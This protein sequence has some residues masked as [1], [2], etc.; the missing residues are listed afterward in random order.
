VSAYVKTVIASLQAQNPK[1]KL[2]LQSVLPREAEAMSSV[3]AYN[4]AYKDLAESMNVDYIDMVEAFA[5]PDGT[6]RSNLTY[7]GLHFNEEGYR[8]WAAQL[9]PYFE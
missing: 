4:Q 3:R 6:L 1:A 8:V 9:A 7:D 2:Y 5:A